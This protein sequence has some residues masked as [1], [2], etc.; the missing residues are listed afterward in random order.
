MVAPK[1]YYEVS[2]VVG[3][4]KTR[5]AAALHARKAGRYFKVHKNDYDNQYTLC[6]LTYRKRK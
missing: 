1:G 2:R 6:Y 4:F 3:K 5:E